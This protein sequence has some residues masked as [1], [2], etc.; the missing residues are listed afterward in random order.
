[1]KSFKYGDI[2]QV[3]LNN[4][5]GSENGASKCY[6]VIISTDA[7]ND[8]L[9]TVIACPLIEAAGVT[10]SRMGATLIPGDA[11]ALDGDYLAFSLQIKTIFK[12]RILRRINSLPQE[13]M[14]Q[15]KE[16]L[17]AVLNFS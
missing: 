1:M 3:E 11:A 10:K 14:Q 13:Y 2:I 15:I 12:K 6:A 8:N 16:S 7:I 5:S 9:N 4:V 17:Q